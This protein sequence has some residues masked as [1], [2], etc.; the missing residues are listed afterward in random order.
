M[1]WSFRE[2][3][4][5]TVI[6]NLRELRVVRVW[7]KL[8]VWNREGLGEEVSS[9]KGWWA[10]VE[11]GLMWETC[12]KRLVNAMRNGTVVVSSSFS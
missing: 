7:A 8:A 2:E 3:A 9:G 10:Q 1:S 4:S 5:D 6:H 11:G 12:W